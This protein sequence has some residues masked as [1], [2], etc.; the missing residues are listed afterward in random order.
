MGISP[1]DYRI[2]FGLLT[3]CMMDGLARNKLNRLK[4]DDGFG[5]DTEC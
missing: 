1:T 4:E 5:G 2:G 3:I